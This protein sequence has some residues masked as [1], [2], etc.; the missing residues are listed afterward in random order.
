MDQPRKLHAGE[1]RPKAELIVAGGA[2]WAA[3]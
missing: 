2:Y 3:W 1:E